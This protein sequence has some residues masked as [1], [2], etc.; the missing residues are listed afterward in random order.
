MKNF[1][2]NKTIFTELAIN[3]GDASDNDNVSNINL[4]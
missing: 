2:A 4:T 1:K 3:E